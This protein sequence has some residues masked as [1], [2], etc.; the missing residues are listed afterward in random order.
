MLGCAGRPKSEAEG[1]VIDDTEISSAAKDYLNAVNK[2]GELEK[3]KEAVKAKLEGVH[4]KTT[5][6]ITIAWSSVAGRKMIDE[7]KVKELLGEVPVRYGKES[8]RLSV[9]GE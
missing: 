1:A 3:V 8:V 9:K 6:G 4:G 5:D 2:I 7:D